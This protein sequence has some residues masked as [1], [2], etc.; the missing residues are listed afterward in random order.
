MTGPALNPEGLKAARAVFDAQPGAVD[1]AIEAYLRVAYPEPQASPEEAARVTAADGTVWVTV[2][3]EKRRAF[4]WALLQEW[5]LVDGR[6]RSEWIK[7]RAF[8]IPASVYDSILESARR[9]LGG[10]E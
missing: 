7:R 10:G 1:K 2:A 9:R 3:V 8:N 4:A 5:K 6:D